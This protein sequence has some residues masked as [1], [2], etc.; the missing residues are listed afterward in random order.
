ME[1][2]EV[3]VGGVAVRTTETVA[4]LPPPQFTVQ[5]PPG[6]PL[7]EES[8]A[9]VKMKTQKKKIRRIMDYPTS[10]EYARPGAE[11]GSSKA[12]PRTNLSLRPGK[13]M[14]ETTR[15]ALVLTGAGGLAGVSDW[16]G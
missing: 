5:P 13:E 10:Q 14:V 9:T 8:S 4:L 15:G 3:G 12:S 7:Q 11:R 1:S 6:T 16:L 2:E